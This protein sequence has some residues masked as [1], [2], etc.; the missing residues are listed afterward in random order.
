M[1][2]EESNEDSQLFLSMKFFDDILT[3]LAGNKME[4]FLCCSNCIR[5]DKERY[6]FDI[7][8]GFVPL[9]SLERCK[10]FQAVIPGGRFKH[11]R[12][13]ENH[14]ILM[15]KEKERKDQEQREQEQKE[16]E[17][18]DQEHK[19]QELEEQKEKVL[20]EQKKRKQNEK[21]MTE[22]KEEEDEEEEELARLR[23]KV[24]I[25]IEK[26][27]HGVMRDI[28]EKPSYDINRVGGK[29]KRTALHTGVQCQ[30]IEALDI[31]LEHVNV[32]CNVRNL[33][34]MSPLMFAA[35]KIKIDSFER[36][37]KDPRVNINLKTENSEDAFDLLPA[38]ASQFER[39]RAKTAFQA[40]K[41][42][43]RKATQK[44]RVAII[45]A[46]SYYEESSMY[47]S[48]PGVK[49]DLEKL[50]A[51]LKKTYHIITIVNAQDIEAKVKE[52]MEGLPDSCLPVTHFQLVY[53]G[54][55]A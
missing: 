20:K 42:R 55:S 16:H 43:A 1:K 38:H 18:K 50:K 35:S 17:Q 23:K 51:F 45:I 30:N 31:L 19:E 5:G 34:G 3:E 8:P 10:S 26:E 24:S 40:A 54:N 41:N 47:P 32:D 6:F 37:L 15:R 22:E 7:G 11:C 4:R 48:L 27:Q 49:E 36:L 28:L 25:A 44:R 29:D 52:E 12:L 2:P 21:E 33:E 14:R 13:D 9:N 39:L 53:A 46:N